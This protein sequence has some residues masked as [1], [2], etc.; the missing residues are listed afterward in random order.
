MVRGPVGPSPW[1]GGEGAARRAAAPPRELCC[2]PGEL[3]VREGGGARAREEE[4]SRHVG[5]RQGESA[6]RPR[7]CAEPRA[8]RGTVTLA[9]S[10]WQGP[11]IG[12]S[13]RGSRSAKPLPSGG[14]RRASRRAAS[15]TP[16]RP[17]W[18]QAWSGKRSCDPWP[19]AG[20]RGRGG[21][22]PAAREAC[23]AAC[24][25]G[26]VRP[27]ATHPPLLAFR[28]RAGVPGVSRSVSQTMERRLGFSMSSW[29]RSCLM[30]A[31]AKPRLVAQPRDLRPRPFQADVGG[32]AAAARVLYHSPGPL[33]RKHP[34]G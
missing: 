18:P 7:R 22:G 28:L 33:A 14:A 23:E 20:A 16:A 13:K 4:I 21:G 5:R 32:S 2:P 19:G 1:R 15:R 17:V 9:M 10:S 24:A 6:R 30:L 34:H 8:P 25:R 31:K 26:C 3:G 11:P 12:I 29:A 27:S